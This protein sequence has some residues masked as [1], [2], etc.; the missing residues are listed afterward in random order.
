MASSPSP[1]AAFPITS[2][3]LDCLRLAEVTKVIQLS[4]SYTVIVGLGAA[5]MAHQLTLIDYGL[6][7]KVQPTDL[8]SHKV[9]QS[10][11][12]SIQATTDFFNYLT[13]IIEIS[14]L[15]STAPNDRAKMI[16]YWTK[17]ADYCLSIRNIQTLKAI[18]SALQGPP[19]AR[20]KKTWGIVPKKTK[21]TLSSL[22]SLVTEQNNY[23]TYRE[24]LKKNTTRPAVPFLGVYI[25]D[26]TYLT[27][28]VKRDGGDLAS[29]KRV[30]EILDQLEYYRTGPDYGNYAESSASQATS[31]PS[32]SPFKKG[33]RADEAAEKELEQEALSQFA[34]HWILT[35]K[36]VSEKEIDE[37]SLLRE[38][39]SS[40][41]SANTPS[42]AQ[43]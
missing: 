7:S 42:T 21:A 8:L 25:H 36:W 23:A 30:R 20:L 13:R 34:S 17:I 35:R 6:F 4:S 39:K 12:P 14:I 37:L 15:E 43:S 18:T 26:L 27:V 19:V 2:F 33:R 1:S 3:E 5:L 29:D 16:Y 10:P 31:G 40:S 38:P 28:V 11:S 41:A 24:W 22:W 9:P 32:I